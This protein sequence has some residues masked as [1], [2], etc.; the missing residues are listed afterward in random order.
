MWDKEQWGIFLIFTGFLIPLGIIFIVMARRENKQDNT[1]EYFN[2]KTFIN[3]TNV[4]D[5]YEHS[6]R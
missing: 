2:S 4:G 1:L 6:Y 3:S 5:S